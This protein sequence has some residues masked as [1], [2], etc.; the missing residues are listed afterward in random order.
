VVLNTHINLWA[1][2]KPEDATDTT[3]EIEN[4]DAGVDE[5]TEVERAGLGDVRCLLSFIETTTKAKLDFIGSSL[6]H[7]VTF[8]D[9]WLL[10]SPGDI[11]IA[12]DGTQAYQV[13][14][15]K[16]TKHRFKQPSDKSRNFWEDET[17]AEVEDNPV[18]ID[19]VYVDYD[20]SA[21]GP[22][23]RT[24]TIS[25]FDGLKDVVSLPVYPL[26]FSRQPDLREKL[27]ERGKLFIKVARMKHMHYCGSSLETHE[28]LDSQVVIDFE[29]ALSRHP[30]WKPI[31]QSVTDKSR[32]KAS[33]TREND[34]SSSDSSSESFTDELAPERR[35][36]RPK[37][38]SPKAIRC[39]PQ[40]CTR[41]VVHDDDYVD[42]R[43]RDEYIASQMNDATSKIP[44]VAAVPRN[45]NDISRDDGLSD[46]EYIIMSFRVFG[47]VLRNRRW[48]MLSSS[49]ACS[50]LKSLTRFPAKLDLANV[51]EVAVLGEGEGFDQ[52]VLPAGHKE[53]V[54]SMIKQH[55]RDKKFAPGNR[56]HTDVV[57][58]KGISEDFSSY[59]FLLTKSTGKG[60][61]MLLHGVPGVGKTS[62]A[63]K[64][65]TYKW[66]M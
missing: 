56:D 49:T 24:F 31:I 15:V 1:I 9:V 44:S 14:H 33:T 35:Y 6:C 18:V 52:L 16:V 25:R 11:V 2:G 62:T 19:C 3:D 40:C 17:K 55:F 58:G 53:M 5:T 4:V 59:G 7:A 47:F 23:R 60:L 38:K 36:Y 46:S 54:K 28:E 48:G 26:R 57:R 10:F 34:G 12:K 42:D 41:E 22:V 64:P 21:V 65:L 8:G 63:G 51:T 32:K 27:V 66:V 37:G 20:G 61:I 29:E 30:K 39:V 50:I 45:L 13:S 43:R